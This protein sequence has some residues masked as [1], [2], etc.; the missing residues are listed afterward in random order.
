[1]AS[2][3]GR[4]QAI[5]ERLPP[6]PGPDPEPDPAWIALAT[7]LL[8]TMDPDHIRQVVEAQHAHERGEKPEPG[9]AH[10]LRV[11]RNLITS[12]YRQEVE[13]GK[14][15]NFRLALPP[16]VAAVFLREPAAWPDDQ[17]AEC[18]LLLPHEWHRTP[19][20]GAVRKVRHFER[21]P[22]CGGRVRMYGRVPGWEPR[23]VRD[24]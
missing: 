3:N 16:A 15:R 23:A 24:G 5:E 17:C 6:D 4:L 22:D 20:T 13:F 18:G 1:M 9:A 10:L 2:L 7:E 11:V 21:C 8:A 12:T 19:A 14:A